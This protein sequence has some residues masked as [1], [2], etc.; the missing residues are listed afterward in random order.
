MI[1]TFPTPTWLYR[2]VRKFAEWIGVWV[3]HDERPLSFDEVR[4]SLI[5][6][7]EILYECTNWPIILTQGVI[8]TRKFKTLK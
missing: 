1:I 4:E 2:I 3:F 5:L 7:G 8:V 6:H